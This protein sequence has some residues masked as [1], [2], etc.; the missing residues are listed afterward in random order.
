MK[1]QLN[2]QAV[3]LLPEKA[4]FLDKS[5]ILLVADTH[6]GKSGTFRQAGVAAPIA[7]NT[8]GVARLDQLIKRINPKRC[9]ILGDF[10]HSRMNQSWKEVAAWTLQ[11]RNP[12]IELVKGNHDILDDLDYS[13][14]GIVLHKEYLDVDGFRLLHD[15][16]EVQKT[17]SSRAD[18]Q[19]SPSLKEKVSD[20]IVSVTNKTQRTHIATHFTISGHIH[21]GIRMKGYAKQSLMLPCFHLSKNGFLLPAF[22]TFTGLAEIRV[23]PDSRIFV[24][25]PQEEVVIEIS[26]DR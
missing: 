2:N 8:D 17:E 15:S 10:F 24:P 7:S 13:R 6:F 16:S 3:T 5:E 11:Q 22:G 1:L 4:M 21:P 23:T 9:I 20:N 25:I 14:A 12:V 19:I 18:K 26:K